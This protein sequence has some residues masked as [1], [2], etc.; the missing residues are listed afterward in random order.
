MPAVVGDELCGG[1]VAGLLVTE[2]PELLTGDG[3]MGAGS[4]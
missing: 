3:D 4:S 1:G 2:P